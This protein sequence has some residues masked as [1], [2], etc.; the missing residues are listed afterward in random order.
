MPNRFPSCLLVS[1]FVISAN[2]APID[3]DQQVYPFLKDNCIACH[4]KTT[5]KGGLNMETPAL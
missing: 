2:A 3:Y 5:T 1:A 4:N